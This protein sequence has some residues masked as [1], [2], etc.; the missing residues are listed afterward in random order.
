[1]RTEPAEHAPSDRSTTGEREI[2][3]VR[4]RLRHDV[5]FAD[6]GDGVLFRHAEASFAV[7][8][9]TAYRFF[10][11]LAPF[12]DGG[13]TVAELEGVI[14]EQQRPMLLHLVGTLL[15]RGFARDSRPSPGTFLDKETTTRFQRQ[16]DYVEHYVDGGH[17]RFARFRDLRVLVVGEG[18]VA[19]RAALGLVRNGA[20]H[21]DTASEAGI[22]TALLEEADQLK[23]EGCP[24]ELRATGLHLS[25]LTPGDLASYNLVL[26]AAGDRSLS[27]VW[28]LCAHERSPPLLTLVVLDGKA[29]MGPFDLRGTESCWNCALL[30]YTETADDTVAARV[31]R[32]LQTGGERPDDVR[33]SG[34]QAAMLGNAL[35]FEAFRWS[36]GVIEG[37]TFGAA[38]VQDLRTLDSVSERIL[39]HPSCPCGHRGIAHPRAALT[40]LAGISPEPDVPEAVEEAYKAT[41]AMVGEHFGIVQD[42]LDL[43]LAQSPLKMSRILLAGEDR[44]GRRVAR[45][46]LHT[47]LRARLRTI[48][49]AALRHVEMGAAHTDPAAV[50]APA[51]FGAH[52]DPQ[53]PLLGSGQ[54]GAATGVHLGQPPGPVVTGIG[55]ADGAAFRVPVAAVHPR[56][57]AN[58]DGLYERT[59]AGEGAGSTIG[60]AV[61][62]GLFGAAALDALQHAAAGSPV[63][64]LDPGTPEA[65]SELEFLTRVI[66][67]LGIETVHFLLPGLVPTVLVRRKEQEEQQEEKGKRDGEPDEGI[68]GLWALGHGSTEIEA[69]VT[70]LR[71]LVAMVQLADEAVPAEEITPVWLEAFDP[72][73]ITVGPTPRGPRTD[74]PPATA[75]HVL[76]LLLQ[77]GR[78]VVVVPTGS[79]DLAVRTGVHTVRAL[80][81]VANGTVTG[82]TAG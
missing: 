78:D 11:A 69:L 10:T 24:V 13:V 70:A 28:R 20:A 31:W 54:L 45:A 79:L 14:P 26:L 16:I 40:D 17:E 71:D 62:A 19:E 80:L 64:R 22:S 58:R 33:I 74:D 47:T 52:G 15:E 63:I 53:S 68:P 50:P 67:T 8:G 21:V 61:H 42:F 43:D 18:P 30:R 44:E 35:A 1:M 60:H 59:H 23:G 73:A 36:T 82:A 2:R 77:Y 12:L 65:G 37:E 55:L 29:V 7:K 3:E 39:P 66:R 76:D 46:D 75:E 48:H 57:S 25:G 56:T 38:L 27:D 72:R 9:R 49:A 6:T 51:Q 81:T 4:P 5:L 32:R 34:P 41:E